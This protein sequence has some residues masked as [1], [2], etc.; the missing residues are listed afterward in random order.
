[1]LGGSLGDLIDR[2]TP[3]GQRTVY[4]RLFSCITMLAL[5]MFYR[6]ALR[7]ERWDDEPCDEVKPFLCRQEIALFAAENQIEME[8]LVGPIVAL[9]VL[10]S[11][12]AVAWRQFL[13]RKRLVQ[14]IERKQQLKVSY[15]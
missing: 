10:G 5:A 2:T 4:R 1:M 9:V 12:L 6:W 13:Q 14:A 15:L 7:S 11:L 8:E 3:V